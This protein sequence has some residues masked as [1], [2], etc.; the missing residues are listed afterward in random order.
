M[1]PVTTEQEEIERANKNRYLSNSLRFL[2]N[3]MLGV[4]MAAN[5]VL[6]SHLL[7]S[8]A[9]QDLILSHYTGTLKMGNGRL[10]TGSDITM[11]RMI[12]LTEMR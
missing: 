8:C 10:E 2:V 1:N 12:T 5:K 7:F 9:S 4:A 11:E 3:K 6:L